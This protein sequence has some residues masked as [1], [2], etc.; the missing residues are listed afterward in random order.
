M[1]NEN[2]TLVEFYRDTVQNN[3]KSEE[4]GRPIFDEF[5]FVRIQTP[6]DTRTLIETIATDQHKKRFPS[7]W[8]LYSRGMEAITEG[9]PLDEWN[10]ATRS[11]AKELQYANIRTVELLAQISDSNI[12]KLGPGYQ[13]LRAKARLFIESSKG[14]AAATA[15]ARENERLREEMAI[16][17]EQLE[18]MKAQLASSGDADEKRGPGRPKKTE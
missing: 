6:G 14:E 3:F 10:G 11:Q 7:A 5:D 12:Q 8:D 18:A 16:M 1:I 17:K 15:A 13:Q 9:T 4:A 2:G